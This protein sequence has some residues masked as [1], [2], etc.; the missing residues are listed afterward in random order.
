ME[1]GAFLRRYPPFDALSEERLRAVVRATEI[2]H[3][4]AGTEILRQSG[5]PAQHLFVVRK[6]EVELLEGHLVL[7]LLGAGEVFGQFS[8]LGGSSPT[9]TVRAHEDTLCYLIDASV[10]DDVLETSAGIRFVVGSM[11]R[12]LRGAI[13]ASQADVADPQM[14]P[15][16]DLIRRP[17]VTVSPGTTVADAAALMTAERTSCLPVLA[18]GEVRP[19][20]IV[21]DRDLRSRIV[22]ER[23]STDTPVEEIATVPALTLASSALAGEALLTMFER[24]I[25]HVPVVDASG[26]LV[27]VVTDTDLMGLEH[28]TPFAVKSAIER[29]SDRDGVSAAGRQL[30]GVVAGL[31]GSGA[32]PV[33]V[34]RVISVA[35]DALTRRLL[36]LGL[37]RLG[38]PPCAWGWLA[39]GS[40]ARHEQ[41]L[42][43]D[44]DHA[45]A[46]EGPASADGWFAEL[47]AFVTDGLEAAGIPR[48]T[49]DAM[50]VHPQMRRPLDEWLR[51]LRTWMQDPGADGSI[52]SSIVY[53]Y[54]Q[55]AGPLRVEAAFD[56]VVRTAK[57][58]PPFLRHLARRALGHAPP[59]GFLRDLV[60]E[61]GGEHAGRLDVKHGGITIVTSLGRAVA[62]GAGLTERRTIE[63]LRAAAAAGTVDRRT[64]EELSEAFRFLWDVRLEH[65][66]AQVRSGEPAD[67]FIAPATLGPVARTGLKEAFRVIG[68]AQRGLA[69]EL[70]VQ[71]P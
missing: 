40:A 63:R 31:V 24:G 62:T 35:V 21:T 23:R 1:V 61:A 7:D 17:P 50:A 54:R 45:L 68:R 27:G 12:R 13:Q 51:S 69:S 44:Q 32:D 15:L 3:F 25:H 52:A 30:P 29:A 56:D 36:H 6:G 34:G 65:Q 67:D 20:G 28:Q 48:C 14:V 39:L 9:V 55:V 8:L 18:P 2:E 60:V 16:A 43:T 49:G 37:E 33:G 10:A 41:A 46:Y 42:R 53:D 58:N 70:G 59:T 71:P 22:A 66:A 4:A 47:A 19:L 64:A 57:D 38:D 26:R 11:R 5:S